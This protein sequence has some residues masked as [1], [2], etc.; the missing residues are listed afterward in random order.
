MLTS[1]GGV[2]TFGVLTKVTVRTIPSTPIAIYNF[3]LQA[4]PNST[5]YWDIVAYFLAQ[6]PTLSAANVSSYTYLLPNIS[7]AEL[8]D[9]VAS[10]EGVFGLLE[11]VSPTALEDMWAPF[12]AHVNETYPNQTITQTTSTVFPNLYSMFLVYADDSG[13]GIDKVVGSR[14]LPPETLTDDAFSDA[15]IDFLGDSGGRLYTVS[16]KGVW[17]AE[18]SGGSDAVNPAS[19]KASIHAGKSS[20]FVVESEIKDSDTLQ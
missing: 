3:N 16:G 13:A 12:W 17:D 19:R 4:E 18:P 10:F 6:F 15:L 11:P 7:A 20:W 5:V 8:G 14:L 1:Q 9:H 2:G